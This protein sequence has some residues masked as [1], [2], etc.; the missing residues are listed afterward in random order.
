MLIK[1]LGVGVVQAFGMDVDG[2]VVLKIYIFSIYFNLCLGKI[3]GF[4]RWGNELRE[5]GSGGGDGGVICSK[6]K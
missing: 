2:G 6:G 1:F 3:V 5:C 4:S